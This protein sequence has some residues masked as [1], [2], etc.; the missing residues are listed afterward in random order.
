MSFSGSPVCPASRCSATPPVETA[1]ISTCAVGTASA[2][3]M[4]ITRT[5][6]RRVEQPP[7]EA[8][9]R[10]HSRGGGRG[11]QA[12][13]DRHA[14]LERH[15]GTI[16]Q[17]TL[18]ARAQR[19]GEVRHRPPDEVDAGEGEQQPEGERERHARHQRRRGGPHERGR[20]GR[21][22]QRPRERPVDPPVHPGVAGRSRVGDRDRRQ[23]RR[24]DLLR[25]GLRIAEQQDRREQE[26]AARPHGPGVD[27]DG[28]ADA[29]EEDPLKHGHT[30]SRPRHARRR[31]R[32]YRTAGHPP[33]Q[34]GDGGCRWQR[35]PP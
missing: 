26:A 29:E 23:R 1:V 22:D 12:A 4:R 5:A 25:R 2:C 30:H 13:P 10:A 33:G 14:V 35:F 32:R 20:Q 17:F 31:R 24:R 11:E 3:G 28:E 15:T 34:A 18:P 21:G 9:Q 6:E 16:A 7:A 27:A 19:L 8:N